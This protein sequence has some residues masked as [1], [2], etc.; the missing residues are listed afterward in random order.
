MAFSPLCN[1]RFQ[2]RRRYLQCA[3]VFHSF[4]DLFFLIKN[5]FS[6]YTAARIIFSFTKVEHIYE[7][8]SMKIKSASI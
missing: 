3:K 4:V 2:D 6:N 1:H 5:I 7:I 8:K